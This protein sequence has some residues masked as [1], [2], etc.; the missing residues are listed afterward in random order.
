LLILNE[1]QFWHVCCTCWGVRRHLLRVAKT[2]LKGGS[3]MSKIFW[4]VALPCAAVLFATG[5]RLAGDSWDKK[6]D[7]KTTRPIEVPGVVLAPGE[8][9]FKLLNTT[10]RHIVEIT[11]M[12]GKQV[13]AIVFTAA[14]RRLVPTAKP[15]MTFFETAAG[16]PDA[17]H[18]WFWPGDLDGQ[19]FLYPHKQAVII[20][21]D[22]G[23]AV[24]EA[25]PE[26]A[27]ETAVAEEAAPAPVETV[28]EVEVPQEVLDA[29]PVQLEPAPKPPVEIAEAAAPLELPSTATNLPLIGLAGLI[30]LAAG[31]AM[32]TRRRTE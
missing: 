2:S 17:V 24:R 28:A 13:Y 11:S 15:T 30:A 18:K 21:K 16:R 14:A 23:V 19:E 31:V 27:A 26:P 5:P 25:P 6:T 20:A 32:R 22:T 10:D 3:L 8:Y 4:K 9:T 29:Q 12:D 7:I 1:I